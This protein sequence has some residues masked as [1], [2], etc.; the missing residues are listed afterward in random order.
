VTVASV[1]VAQAGYINWIQ[2]T[3]TTYTVAVN[4]QTDYITVT[5]TA[6]ATAAIAAAVTAHEADTTAVHGITNTASLSTTTIATDT[7]WAAKGDLVVG[8][9]N[10]TAAVLTAGTNAYQLIA[11]SSTA[12]GLKWVTG[13]T[14]AQTADVAT[15]ETTTSATYVDLATSGP[16]VTLNAPPSGLIFLSYGAVVAHSSLNAQTLLSPATSGG[17]TVAATDVDAAWHKA[18]TVTNGYSCEKTKLVTGLTAGTSYT[19]TLKYRTT[20]S[21]ATILDRRIIA[22]PL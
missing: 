22:I 7:L 3:G 15:S 19:F 12:S 5:D 16:A 2:G 6:D 11:D 13:V 9:A 8:T 20:A 21:T 18:E 10:D 1:V 14:A 17:A 4:A